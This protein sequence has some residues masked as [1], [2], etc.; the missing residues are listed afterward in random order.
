MRRPVTVRGFQRV[1]N[2]TAF[3]QEQALFRHG[4]T[5]DVSAQPLE[6]VALAGFD[7]HTGVQ[8]EARHVAGAASCPVLLIANRQG[9]EGLA[10]AVSAIKCSDQKSG[11]GS[12]VG[13][14]I[15]EIPAPKNHSWF[16]R[17]HIA[18]AEP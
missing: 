6:F 14:L 15:A 16:G 2:L 8:G 10:M 12:L 4:R 1:A 11:Y 3:G 5:A 17:R 13:N 9:L 18:P 7:R